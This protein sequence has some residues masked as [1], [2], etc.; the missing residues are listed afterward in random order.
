MKQ[1]YFLL[2]YLVVMMMIGVF[3][4]SFVF[5]QATL[6]HSYTFE[7]GTANDGTGSADGTLQGDAS[8]V[9]GAVILTGGGFVSLPGQEININ[10][11]SAISVEAVF[12]QGLGL[13]SQF[14]VLYC[15]GETNNDPGWPMGIDY[16]IYQPTRQDNDYSRF[17]VSCDDTSSPWSTE[18][19]INGKEIVDTEKHYVVTI[20]TATEM[21]LYLDGALLGT[22]TLSEKNKIANLS[23]DTVLIGESVYTNDA[24]WIGEFHEMNIF[25]G[26]LDEKTIVNRAEQLLGIPVA[27]ASLSGITT[28]KGDISPEFDPET[29]IYELMVEYGTTQI[30]IEPTTIV[31]GAAVQILDFFGNEIENGIVNF[32]GDGIDMEII[33]TALNGSTQQSYYVSVFLYPEEETASLVDIEL[34]TGSLLG[35]FDM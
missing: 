27:N 33:V 35:D 19:G 11:Y 31:K 25:E 22:E 30:T 26:E 15:F 1:R 29:E 17:S 4:M 10:E 18:S 20:L 14:S 21:K 3:S 24:N 23:N 9:N 28:N 32:T 6:K 2:R 34:S 7:D 12:K 5:G 16:L 13:E 8:I